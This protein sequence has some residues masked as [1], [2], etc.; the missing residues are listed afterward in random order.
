MI[1]RRPSD[2]RE[3]LQLLTACPRSANAIRLRHHRSIRER[4]GEAHFDSREDLDS[5]D[6]MNCRSRHS[7]GGIRCGSLSQSGFIMDED[8]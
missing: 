1:S 8:Q 2:E 5:A 6:G 4:L 3:Q 7:K